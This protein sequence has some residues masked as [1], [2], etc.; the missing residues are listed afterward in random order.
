MTPQR[1]QR[2]D[3]PACDFEFGSVDLRMEL[4][5]FLIFGRQIGS[6]SRH[7]MIRPHTQHR[8]LAYARRAATNMKTA[9]HGNV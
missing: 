9:Q 5:S 4:A 7:V 8:K 3:P 6:S 2:L 1:I